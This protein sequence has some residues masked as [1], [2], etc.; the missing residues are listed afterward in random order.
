MH[1]DKL[2]LST[3]SLMSISPFT[4]SRRIFCN[5][6]S[7]LICT[8]PQDGVF[9]ASSR[10]KLLYDSGASILHPLHSRFNLSINEANAV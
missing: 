7:P 10:K 3:L 4:T 8:I 9:L 1:F 2:S 6:S 5:S